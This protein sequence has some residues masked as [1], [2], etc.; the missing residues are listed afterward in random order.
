MPYVYFGVH[1]RVPTSFF[2]LEDPVSY[3]ILKNLLK[4]QM[5]SAERRE[6]RQISQMNAILDYAVKR[7]PYYT[8]KYKNQKLNIYSIKDFTRL[9]ELSK[10]EF[11]ANNEAILSRDFNKNQVKVLYTSGSTGIPVKIHLSKEFLHWKKALLLR[12]Y[13]RMGYRVG[14]RSAVLW[15]SPRYL[16]AKRIW[17][18]IENF[19][20]NVR[21]MRTFK[22]T[23]RDMRDY[24]A[25]L[26]RFKPK[27]METYVS[28]TLLLGE[29]V[30]KYGYKV[31]PKAIQTASEV[32][33]PNKRK[34]I[35]DVFS[36]EVFDR[37][38]ANEVGPIAGECITHES[39]HIDSESVYVEINEKG[40]MLITNLL[41][42]AMPLIRYNIG[43]IN[44]MDGK[45]H[46]CGL[47]LP[48]M[49]HLSGRSNDLI[50]TTS[51]DF[52]DSYFFMALMDSIPGIKKFK[53]VQNRN[54]SI[55][56]FIVRGEGYDQERAELTI[57]NTLMRMDSNAKSIIRYENEVHGEE[58]GKFRYVI[59]KAD[60]TWR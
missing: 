59:S 8:A 42:Y 48:S 33:L 60:T 41:N 27:V 34:Y 56:I 49:G 3:D 50:K 7:I 24:A 55:D 53:V 44:K 39:M 23:E 58:S 40:E 16:K 18:K 28:A 30:Q 1:P 51:G 14:D 35:E 2:R 25:F 26:E 4:T 17:E 22:I 12:H 31:E 36:C 21:E 6:R 43:D 47:T 37:Y 57:G 46:N 13:Y 45:E 38:G 32:L 20:M 10:S 19:F 52:V 54:L 9:P 29:V 11:K 15:G 5:E